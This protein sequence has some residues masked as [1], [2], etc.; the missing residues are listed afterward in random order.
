MQREEDLSTHK[1]KNIGN[2]DLST[3]P[4][5]RSSYMKYLRMTFRDNLIK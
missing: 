3:A 2:L 1:V 4:A 5:D